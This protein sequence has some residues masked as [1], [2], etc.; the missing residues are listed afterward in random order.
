MALRAAR[1]RVDIFARNVVSGTS[2][3]LGLAL[4]ALRCA[5]SSLL[6][7]NATRTIIQWWYGKCRLCRLSACLS[8]YLSVFKHDLL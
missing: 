3:A 4:I 5:V 6:A 8:A 2:Q 1:L 7:M